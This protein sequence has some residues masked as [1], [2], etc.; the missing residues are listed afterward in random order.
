MEHG[1]RR[2]LREQLYRAFVTRASARRARQH[3]AH[4]AHPAR[5]GASRRALLGFA[6]YAEL[7]LATQDGARRR[8]GRAAARGAARGVVRRRAARP[9]RAARV[10]A[11]ATARPRRTS[12][13][14]GTSPSGPSA[15]ARSAT[16]TATRSCGPYFPLPR[17]LDGLFA[18]AERL[19]GV[20]IARR[21]RRGA[22]LAPR[23]ALLPRRRRAT[24]QPLAAFYLDPYSRPAEKRGGAWMDE[25]V[26]RARAGAACA[27]RSPTSSAT[28]R[29]RSATSPSLHD[30]STRCETLFHEFGH[31]LQHMLTRVEHGRSPSGIRNVEWDAVEL[32]SQFMENWC[33]HRETLL[34]LV[35]PRRD[36]RAAARRAVREAASP[37]AP[38]APARTCC[39]SSTSRS[40][41]LELHQRC[42][43]DGARVGLRRPAA[44]RRAH[45][46]AAAAA[47][48]PLPVQLHATSSRAATRPATTATSGPRCCR[49]TPSRAFEEAGLEDAARRARRRA[50][51][52]ATP[53]SRSAAAATRWTSSRRSAAASRAPR[54]CCGRRACRAAGRLRLDL[55]L[56]ADLVE[57][58]DSQ[59]GKG[60]QVLRRQEDVRRIQRVPGLLAQA[61]HP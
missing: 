46:G 57:R 48:G 49:P 26:G 56:H 39:A 17:V 20:R 15:C 3:A 18:L 38:T 23:R 30:A 44:H 7:S 47:R 35:A 11:R 14:T 16:P 60:P 51:A 28:R 22:G 25:C 54:R 29:R 4:R 27:C 52:S 10:R 9:R 59:V 31:G 58:I 13:R 40:L 24:A 6:S 36:G 1:R 37:R 2:D 50:G 34:G 8:G 5:C 12:S 19:F 43:P 32:P 33:Y 61:H 41:D 45:H 53:C 55:R 21:R 42:D